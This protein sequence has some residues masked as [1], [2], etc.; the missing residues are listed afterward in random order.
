MPNSASN[1]K[2][3]KIRKRHKRK[4]YR[5]MKNDKNKIIKPIAS[6]QNHHPEYFNQSGH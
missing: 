2:I 1:S 6:F 3:K 5:A 4:N